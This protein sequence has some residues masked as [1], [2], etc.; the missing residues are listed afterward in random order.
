MAGIRY[1]RCR[2][3]MSRIQ[4]L[5]QIGTKILRDK[6]GKSSL[7]SEKEVNPAD[8]TLAGIANEVKITCPGCTEK[9]CWEPN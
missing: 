7:S 5:A 8:A 9:Q 2:Y 6:Y 4:A 3:I 1:T